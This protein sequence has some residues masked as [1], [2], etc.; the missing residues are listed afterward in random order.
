MTNV[1]IS[2][3]SL[4]YMSLFSY[5]ND[6]VYFVSLLVLTSK[7][8]KVK[9]EAQG[10]PPGWH[11]EGGGLFFYLLFLIQIFYLKFM[12]DLIMSLT[13]HWL[14]DVEKDGNEHDHDK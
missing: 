10:H 2:F 11:F 8:F 9:F 3:Q 13:M 7:K 14:D 6:A 12:F 1:F 5:E 4:A